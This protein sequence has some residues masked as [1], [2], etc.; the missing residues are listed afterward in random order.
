MTINFN[1]NKALE[2]FNE[3]LRG[4]IPISQLDQLKNGVLL[5]PE[6]SIS[7]QKWFV[8]SYGWFFPLE[9][10]PGVEYGPFY[11]V[12]GDEFWPQIGSPDDTYSENKCFYGFRKPPNIRW[13]KKYLGPKSENTMQYIYQF[14]IRASREDFFNSPLMFIGPIR[15]A[16]GFQANPNRTTVRIIQMEIM[17][18]RVVRYPRINDAYDENSEPYN[19]N[20]NKEI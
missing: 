11:R 15:N 1:F 12:N 20:L 18:N 5:N 10:L 19:F 16:L 4:R 14:T 2:L 6:L 13:I 9:I 7:P 8:E 17:N 3:I